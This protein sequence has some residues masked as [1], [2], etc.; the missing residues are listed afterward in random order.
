MDGYSL[1]TSVYA[2]YTYAASI[3]LYATQSRIS[4]KVK[5]YR[6]D[7]F[8]SIIKASRFHAFESSNREG[9]NRPTKFTV[10]VISLFRIIHYID[11]EYYI[12][13]ENTQSY[14]R[15]RITAMR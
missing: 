12:I 4:N 9:D 15:S 6:Y 1:Y 14:T 5:S 8:F 11:K 10:D 7:A 3:S 13:F 2:S